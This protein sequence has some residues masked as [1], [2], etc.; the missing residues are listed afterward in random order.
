MN[1]SA[2]LRRA[3]KT[4]LA[5]FLGCNMIFLMPALAQTRVDSG[6]ASAPAASDTLAE[7]APRP[8]LP[9]LI[10]EQ[11][12]GFLGLPGPMQAGTKASS[13]AARSNGDGAAH[14]PFAQDDPTQGRRSGSLKLS[15]LNPLQ[16]AKDKARNYGT[17]WLNASAETWLSGLVDNGRARVNFNIDWDGHLQGEGDV[18]LPLYDTPHTT[19]FTQIGARSMASDDDKDRWIGN[20]GL[21]Q[22]WFPYAKDLQNAGNLMFGYNAFFDRDFTRS[23]QRGGVGGEIQY[24]WLRLASNYYFPL[25]GWKGSP[26]FDR[27]LIEERPAKGWDVRLKAYWPTYRNLAFTGAY[28]RWSGEHVGV[29]GAKHLEKDPR[30]WSYGIEYTP[31]PLFS[32]FIKQRHVEGSRNETEFG[33]NFTYRFGMPWEKQTR[34]SSVAEL[35]SVSA[36]RH[37]FVDRENKI[38]LEYRAKKAYHIELT[39]FD[40]NSGEFVFRLRNGFDEFP[41]GVTVHVRA[42]N[43]ATLAMNEAIA[44]THFLARAANALRGIFSIKTAHAADFSKTYVTRGGGYIQGT[45][46][47]TVTGPVTITAQAGNST[48]SFTVNVIGVNDV[49]SLSADADSIP[50]ARALS[51]GATLS[52]KAYKDGIAQ[53]QQNVRWSIVSDAAGSALLNAQ[54]STDDQGRA[55]AVLKLAS[56]GAGPI[57][58]KAELAGDSNTQAEVTV[59]VTKVAEVPTL[60]QAPT[61]DTD[62]ALADGAAENRLSLQVHDSANGIH[63]GAGLTVAWTLVSPDPATGLTLA[64]NGI[65]T[66]NADGVAEMSVTDSSG[67]AREVTLKATLE[68]NGGAS[69]EQSVTAHFTAVAYALPE[70]VTVLADAALPDGKAENKLSVQVYDISHN[71]NAG[72]GVT[73]TWSIASPDPAT[74]LTLANNGVSVTNASGVAEMSVTDSE[75]QARAVTLLA[76]VDG[77]GAGK[78]QSA[79][80]NFAAISYA[81][82]NA[83]S[84]ISDNAL[85]NGKAENKLRVQVYDISHNANAG[86]GVTVTWSIVS[87]NPATGLTLANNG[88]STTNAGGVAEMSVTD[89]GGLARA[90]ILKATVEGSGTSAAGREQNATVR[91]T[92]SYA[93]PNAMN[94]ETDYSPP[95]GVTANRLS[96]QVYDNANGRNAGAGVTVTWTITSPNP[97]T[98]LTLANGGVSTTNAG[99]V[100]EMSVTDNSGLTRA[101]TLRARVGVG[102]A[103]KEQSATVNFAAPAPSPSYTLEATPTALTQHAATS[104]TFT[105]K[106]GGT[107]VPSGTAVTF[108]A[109]ANPSFTNLPGGTPTTDGSGQIIVPNLTATA[110]GAQTVSAT[111]AGQTVSVSFTVTAAAYTLE[112]TPT[113]LTRNTP[114]S[115]TFTVKQDGTAVPSGAAVTFSANSNFTNLPT[116]AQSTDG[117]GQITV[118]N[119]T[120]TA[121][122]TQTVSATVGGQAVSVSFTVTAPYTLEATPTALTQ[123]TPASVT[124]TVKQDGAAVPS[125]TAV[126]FST[127]TNFTNLPT[128]APTTDA[129]GQIIVPNLTATAAG[130]QTVSATVAGQTVSVSFTVTAPYTL[131]ATPVT[132][133]QNTP[134]SVTFTVKQGGAAVPSGAAVTFSASANPNFTNL[135]GGAQTT[136]ASGQITVSSLTATVAGTQ[137]VS[138]SIGGQTVSVDF[139][140]TAPALIS[141]INVVNG[142]SFTSGTL[143]ST[144]SFQA[145]V[146]DASGNPVSSATV[147]WSVLSAQNNAPAMMSGWRS[148][149]TG[150]TWGNVPE[151]NLTYA[152]LQ[153]ERISSASSPTAATIGT[154]ETPVQQLTDIVGQREITIQA[155][156]NIGGTDYTA[157]QPVSFGSGP[158]SVFSRVGTGVVQWSPN[159]SSDNTRANA[160]SFQHLNNSFPAA[161]FC[162]GTVN[163]DVTSTGPAG[164][165]SAGF[166]PNSGGWSTAYTPVGSTSYQARN[167]ENSHLPTTAQLL[168]VAAPNSSYTNVLE[169]Q[170]AAVA[171]GWLD[172]SYSAWTGEVPFNGSN[173]YAMV[174][175]LDNGN[176]TRNNVDNTNPVAVCRP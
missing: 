115:V 38:I 73:V 35:R 141:I 20:I 50:V 119:L 126:T 168:A 167:A 130:T 93:L 33:L 5:L 95:D 94:V 171:A 65:S 57:V 90:V 34:H 88:I 4:L 139:T 41:D 42:S 107:A 91:F 158:L 17:N 58:V 111:V 29:F 162:G 156:V 106:Q 147:T 12:T 163:N 145:K 76:T 63:A 116:G 153:Q 101:V 89:S 122:G 152:D 64:N 161:A 67:L 98:G 86:A 176:V 28:T 118:S 40:R 7:A 52:F 10:L 108:S 74:G 11:V 159:S 18:L 170:G 43:G 27:R 105:V 155:K 172:A 92:D 131:E 109:S 165:N 164:T 112:A 99:G 61:L 26:D 39:R 79:T 114:A 6:P 125:G 55:T 8:S 127:N 85:A 56:A 175:R 24:D 132:L 21:G 124:F 135:P 15:E 22:R 32:G 72:A 46:T 148:K 23:H 71:A 143:Y 97:A 84:V 104:V 136:D 13:A 3:R 2:C 14:D 45:L 140:V 60:P 59:T 138:A 44:P 128:G 83:V 16:M 102:G 36:S 96:V 48:A 54:S 110:A 142:P 150:L 157:T 68:G 149:K 120:A 173:F 1:T 81:L 25:S 66:T 31:L 30:E 53:T 117:S 51:A 137:T 160:S 77:G 82:P 9:H 80:V 169:R 134:A 70:P 133:T 174:V 123:N 113:T 87:P 37:E 166:D 129:S 121:A 47:N 19:I 146:V 154:G 62:N 144:A 78:E 75:G 49:T 69:Q 151:S 100:A 103:G